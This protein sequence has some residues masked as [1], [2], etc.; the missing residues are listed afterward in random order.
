MSQVD[1][2]ATEGLLNQGFE[3]IF[4]EMARYLTGLMNPVATIDY[5]TFLKV[6]I[7]KQILPF[8]YQLDA[9][10]SKSCGPDRGRNSKWCK[11]SDLKDFKEMPWI[12]QIK[13][14]IYENFVDGIHCIY[15]LSEGKTYEWI[16]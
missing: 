2:N 12:K 3:I 7:S 10:K 9:R 13:V 6:K 11:L 8:D 14:L 1:S 4:K 16:V 15:E 5:N